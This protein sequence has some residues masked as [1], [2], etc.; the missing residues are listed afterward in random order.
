MGDLSPEPFALR[1]CEP[2]ALGEMGRG[3]GEM[4]GRRL[5]VH[6]LQNWGA[7]VRWGAM[8]G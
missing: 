5:E 3:M 4:A 6:S 7:M 8:V 2:D 1:C